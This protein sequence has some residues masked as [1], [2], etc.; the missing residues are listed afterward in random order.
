LG[1]KLKT[2]EVVANVASG[3][4]GRTAPAE[5]QAILTAA[6]V[7]HQVWS[8]EPH[9]IIS[10]LSAAIARK[11]DLLVVLAGDGTARAAAE[12]SGPNG[13][14]IAPLP[15]GTMNMLPHAVYGIRPWQAALKLA[16]EQGYE[17]PIGGGVVEGNSFLVAGIF[18]SPALWAPA[19]EAARFGQPRLAWLRARRAMRRTFHGRLR[20]I[21]DDREREKAEALIFMCPLTSRAMKNDEMALEAA[22]LDVHGAGDLIRLGLHAVTGDWRDTPGVEV[23]HCQ[24]ARVWA[25][26][27]IPAILDGETVQLKTLAEVRYVAR[28]ARILAIPAEARG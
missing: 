28:L 4:V 26:H 21:L 7:T 9:D 2:V 15:G 19:R 5:A 17:Q 14:L 3:S 1:A 27:G 8:P 12:L 10:C 6:G 22:A 16:L 18:G 23:T 24:K 11:P 13:P 25:A 20:F